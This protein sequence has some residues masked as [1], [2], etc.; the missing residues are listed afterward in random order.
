MSKRKNINKTTHDPRKKTDGSFI[1]GE[2][3]AFYDEI[4]ELLRVERNMRGSSKS[5]T[6]NQ[7]LSDFLKN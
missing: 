7:S 3:T 2:E 1:P 6:A 4:T 5:V